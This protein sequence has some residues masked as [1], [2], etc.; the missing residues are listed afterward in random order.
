MG[1]PPLYVDVAVARPTANSYLKMGS[2]LRPGRASRSKEASKLYHYRDMIGDGLPIATGHL[3][4]AIFESGG[5]LGKRL[6]GLLHECALLRAGVPKGS[7]FTEAASATYQ[8]YLQ[9]LSV[10]L[11]TLEA[12]MVLHSAEYLFGA[13]VPP[14]P[15]PSGPMLAE[16]VDLFF[17]GL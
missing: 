12:D 4:P 7:A 10:R 3:V 16:M 2:A 13:S 5:R 15:A 17:G 9:R 11:Q 1:L 8:F 14:V 6:D